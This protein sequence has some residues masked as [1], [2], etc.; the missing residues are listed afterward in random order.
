MTCYLAGIPVGVRRA[1]VVQLR[2]EF[3]YGG[4]PLIIHPENIEWTGSWR[5]GDLGW[6]A[7]ALLK[8]ARNARKRIS[9]RSYRPLSE[10]G[11]SEIR[12]EWLSPEY[13][14]IHPSKVDTQQCVE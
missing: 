7:D 10:Y 8:L 14:V 11:H 2:R 9:L 13:V 3:A 6:R 5:A 1:L 12:I 4:K